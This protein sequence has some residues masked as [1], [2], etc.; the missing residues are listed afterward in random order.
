M[1]KG[2]CV[3]LL[4]VMNVG[5]SFMVIGFGEAGFGNEKSFFKAKIFL[6]LSQKNII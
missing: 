5:G 4:K 1:A 3:N 2:I 6:N